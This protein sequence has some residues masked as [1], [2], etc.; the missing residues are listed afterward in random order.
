MKKSQTINMS[1]FS[2]ETSFV[3]FF[4]LRNIEGLQS[5]AVFKFRFYTSFGLKA[6]KLPWQN[7]FKN[8]ILLV[9]LKDIMVRVKDE[10]KKNFST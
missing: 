4:F 3:C 8:D 5:S 9:E 6:V 7:H 1:S 10:I 2:W